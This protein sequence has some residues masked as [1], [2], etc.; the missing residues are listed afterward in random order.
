MRRSM[1]RQAEAERER[2]ARV[3]VADAE[4]Q[5]SAK[6]SQAASV[7]ANTPGA[8]QLRMLQTVVDVASEKN[9]T[10]VMPFPVELLRF[11]D[12]NTSA[13]LVRATEQRATEQRAT[14]QRATDQWVPEPL[15][16][17]QRVTEPRVDGQ[18]AATTD[19]PA[20]PE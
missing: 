17:E 10:L 16:S 14:E 9:S 11:F 12:R 19:F 15:A 5:A 13:D 18:L 20:D 4:L 1:S 7:M 2:R 6:L 3:I 8:L